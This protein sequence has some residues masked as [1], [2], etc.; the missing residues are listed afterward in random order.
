[1]VFGQTLQLVATGTYTDGSTR[2]ISSTVIWS[3]STPQATNL[4]TSGLLTSTA[5]GTSS[6]TATSGS[7]SGSTT[8]TIAAGTATETLL[9]TF[10][11][12]ETDG[13]QPVAMIEANDGNFYGTAASGSPNSCFSTPTFCGALFKVTPTG[14]ETIVYFFGASRI[15]GYWPNSLL[16]ASDGNFYGTT[17]SGGANGGGT[18][19]KITPGGAETVLYSFAATAADGYSPNSLMQASDGNFYGTTASGGANY[20][21]QIPGTAHNCGT[22]FMITSA[23]VETVLYSFGAS[24]ADGVE[25]GSLM[26]ANDGN[27]YGT[28]SGGGAYACG[29]IPGATNNCGTV[30]KVT[31]AGAATVLWSFGG[32]TAD[33]IAPQ[34]K[35]IQ[36]TDGDLYGTTAGGGGLSCHDPNSCGGTLFRIS[37][38]GA[39][40]IVYQ[41]SS[42]LADLGSPSWVLFQGRDGNFYGTTVDGGPYENPGGIAYRITPGGAETTLYSFGASATD[43]TR[44]FT[45]LQASDGNLYGTTNSGGSALIGGVPVADAGTAFKLVLSP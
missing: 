27:F 22:V 2:D 44:P 11:P 1:M 29:D 20:C 35:L 39:E 19:F 41:F 25:P 6:V 30:F 24:V 42:N 21:A 9:H 37:L 45:L 36:A 13:L 33:G 43:G 7:I 34:G 16:Q 26:Q 8:V 28:T 32:T 5:I 14:V 40:S 12:G 18:V 3:S 23:G 15:D 17:S 10:G 38:S 31:P 4:G